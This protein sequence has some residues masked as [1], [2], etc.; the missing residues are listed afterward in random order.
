[1]GPRSIIRFDLS[2]MPR[3]GLSL[4]SLLKSLLSVKTLLQCLLPYDQLQHS[5][6]TPQLACIR[7][8]LAIIC[9]HTLFLSLDSKLLQGVASPQEN[10]YILPSIVVLN[11]HIQALKVNQSNDYH[12]MF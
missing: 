12:L 1:M 4:P 11:W 7:N 3:P 5:L 6:Y 8:C 2:K 10:L 9:L